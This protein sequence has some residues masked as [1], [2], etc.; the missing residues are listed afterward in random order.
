LSI[1]R[2]YNELFN[3]LLEGKL[4]PEEARLLSEWLGK[5]QL[6]QE[7]EALIL[8]QMEQPMG[9]NVA[10]PELMDKLRQKLPFI[11]NAPAEKAKVISFPLRWI[12]YAAVLLICLSLA[13]LFIARKQAAPTSVAVVPKPVLI[14]DRAPGKEGAI[15]TLADGTTVLLDTLGNGVIA[16]QNGSEVRLDNGK[17]L[18]QPQGNTDASM[19]YNTISTPKGRQ[20][21]LVLSDGSKVWL[22][23]GSSLRFPTV[24]TGNERRVE[25]IGE[26]YFEVAKNK[27]MPFRVSINKETEIEVVGTHFNINS[28]ANEE[29]I[30]TSLLE[31]AVNVRS[32][33]GGKQTKVALLPGQQAKV[34]DGE[35][36]VD[37]NVN[38]SRVMAWKNGIFDFQDAT[39]EEV[40]R[41]I[42]R[43]YDIEV[44]YEKGIPNL[45]FV[46]KIGRDL[47]LMNVL[48]GLELSGVKFKLEGS[49]LTMMP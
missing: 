24:F 44:V 8:E 2:N 18:Y 32:W 4:S 16:L 20:F 27:Q 9:K 6:D 13:A 23:A 3:R 26:G 17:V 37:H 49:R 35:C 25:I 43:W 39:L 31:G 34:K 19:V 12:R 36:L 5:D 30:N 7:A 1:N 38:M 48:R 33:S 41:Q 42:E 46:G 40:M 22:N 10:D 47:S 45:E 29:S 15:L 21:Q 11:L 14:N 28:Y